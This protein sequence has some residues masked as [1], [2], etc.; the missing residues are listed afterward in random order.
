MHRYAERFSKWEWL[1]VWLYSIVG[2]TLTLGSDVLAQDARLNHSIEDYFRIE[3]EAKVPF[4]LFASYQA[5][6]HIVSDTIY[7]YNGSN[8]EGDRHSITLYY[9]T[10]QKPHF[11]SMIFEVPDEYAVNQRFPLIDFGISDKFVVFLLLGRLLVFD[12]GGHGGELRYVNELGYYYN[13]VRLHGSTCTLLEARW[14]D[15]TRDP[16]PARLCRLDVPSGKLLSILPIEIPE[17]IIFTIE[18]PCQL[19]AFQTAELAVAS[20]PRYHVTIYDSTLSVQDHLDRIPADW[21][22]L[23][24]TEWE[25][26]FPAGKPLST[27][28][29]MQWLDPKTDSF[30]MIKRID[31]L[32]DSTLMVSWFKR[33]FHHSGPLANKLESGYDLWRHRG[34]WILLDSNL[35]EGDS[36]FYRRTQLGAMLPP[37]F[38]YSSDEGRLICLTPLLMDNP[39]NTP[40][41]QI[42]RRSTEYTKQHDPTY[43][44]YVLILK[45][46]LQ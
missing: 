26:K 9:S 17:G 23:S 20:R 45:T 12:R 6:A 16:S 37:S 39:P 22:Q 4:N 34:R 10:L 41:E 42:V 40:Y 18:Q 38:D 8:F 27:R 36:A 21:K 33:R 30:S 25:P 3:F 44:V 28:M 31:F 19:A 15:P 13:S 14:V 35:C 1:R 2:M 5:L 11:D 29:I 46:R 7:L 24:D 43:T 32:N